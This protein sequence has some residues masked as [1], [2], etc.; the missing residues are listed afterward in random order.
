[1]ILSVLRLHPC[2]KDVLMLPWVSLP[3]AHSVYVTL[4]SFLIGFLSSLMCVL[5]FVFFLNLKWCCLHFTAILTF[6]LSRCRWIYLWS[7]W[8]GLIVAALEGR[9]SN[10]YA[11]TKVFFFWPTWNCT[12]I[13]SHRWIYLSWND[14]GWSQRELKWYLFVFHVLCR[15]K[16]LKSLHCIPIWSIGT[17]FVA[18]EP[19]ICLSDLPAPDRYAPGGLEF[20]FILY[21]LWDSKRADPS[22]RVK[23]GSYPKSKICTS[24]ICFIC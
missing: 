11:C 9:L 3:E 5:K 19:F 17:S 16:S 24:K 22:G 7:C 4:A 10:F 13:L 12:N 23:S 2:E 6:L 15:V 14:L 20:R 21:R 18:S 1:M 8:E